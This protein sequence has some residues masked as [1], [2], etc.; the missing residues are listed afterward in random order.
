[1]KLLD[2]YADWCGPCKVLLK[3][4]EQFSEKHPDV[5]IIKINI[6]EN[7]EEAEAWGVRNIPSVFLIDDTIQGTEPNF[8]RKFVGVKT[9][10][11]LEDFVYEDSSRK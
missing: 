5:P 2:F 3:T 9:L 10:K 1:M 6:E 8:I 7:E 11:D 4:F